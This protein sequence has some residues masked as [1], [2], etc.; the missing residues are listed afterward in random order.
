MTRF[1]SY[2]QYHDWLWSSHATG[3]GIGSHDINLDLPEKS[4]LNTWIVKYC[5]EDK[6]I[7]LA[8]SDR[9]T[10]LVTK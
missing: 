4:S 9:G 6:T 3:Q 10:N 7:F 2:N 1:V 5:I 8:A